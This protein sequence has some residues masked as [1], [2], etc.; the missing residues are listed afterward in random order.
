MK[1][2]RFAGII[3]VVLWGLCEQSPA[4]LQDVSAPRF[5]SARL[6]QLVAPIALYPDSLLT[7][8]MMAATYPIEVVEADRWVRAN[9]NVTGDAL[10]TSLASQTWDPSVKALAGLPDVL[11]MMSE[12]LDWTRDLG[13]A[14]L[15]QR[16]ELMD[17]V[18][19]MRARAREAG[20]LQSTDQ[21]TVTVQDPG[22]VVIESRSP[23]VIYVPMYSP[24]AV[25]GGWSYPNW[26]YPSFYGSGY[27]GSGYGYGGYGSGT[28]S[29]Y[30][31][32][33]AFS[34][35]FNWGNWL[36][37]SPNWGYGSS[38]VYVD[39][40]R[41][42][43]FNQYWSSNWT[44]PSYAGDRYPGRT[45]PSIVTPVSRSGDR[46]PVRRD[47]PLRHA[48]ARSRLRDDRA[49]NLDGTDRAGAHLARSRRAAS[50]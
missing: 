29:G 12:N 46:A 50:G 32:G 41:Y 39:A 33:L 18:Q 49:A 17:A 27:Y 43:R 40:A 8:V 20:T 31:S 28:A 23:E 15:S 10:R 37:G 45:V 5:D 14:F 2:T 6:E 47:G 22:T 30:G 3:A 16:T 13:D 19:R 35:G 38:N 34:I 4:Q 25:Y 36:W 42:N 21:Q 24:R 26:Y 44:Q 9:P 7:H 48:A 1:T 11:K